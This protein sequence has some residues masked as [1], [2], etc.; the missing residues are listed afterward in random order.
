MAT[1]LLSRLNSVFR[2]DIPLQTIFEKKTAAALAQTVIS[3]Q[4]KPGQA[5]Q[6]ARLFIK[7]SKMSPGEV[8]ALLSNKSKARST[9]EYQWA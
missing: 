6:I 3:R 7:V 8:N 1:Q 2:V 5:D 9:N 4:A